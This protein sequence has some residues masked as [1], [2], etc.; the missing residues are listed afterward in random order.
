MPQRVFDDANIFYSRTLLDWLYYLRQAN[1]GMF[2]LHSTE[3]VFA[4]VLANMREKDPTA[5]GHVT[6]HRLEL[7]QECIDEVIQDFAG[8]AEFT[9]T[10]S[11]DYHVHAAALGARSDLV[12]TADKPSGITTTPD[13]QPYEIISPDDFFMLVVDSS[14]TCLL[15]IVRLQFDYWKTKPNHRQLDDA[16]ER[17]GCQQFALRVRAALSRLAQTVY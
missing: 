7:M 1:E 12:V 3:D 2:Q 14:P 6:R 5:P 11:E 16:L 15:P 10:D 17:A 8:D 4:E 13:A 9:G